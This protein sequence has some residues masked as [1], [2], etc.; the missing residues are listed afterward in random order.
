MEHDISKGYT[1][2]NGFA[3]TAISYP[4]NVHDAI[5]V[6]CKGVSDCE[7]PQ[8]DIPDHT[9]EDYVIFIN[10]MKIQKAVI[11]L[12]N[13]ACI[14]MCPSLKYIQ[15]IPSYQ[16]DAS[17]VFSPLYEMPEIKSLSCQNRYGSREQFISEVDYSRIRG[18]I[19]LSI[20]VNRKTLN[21]NRVKTLK[22]LDVGGFKGKNHDLTDLFSSEELDTLR[23][24]QCGMYSLNGIETSRKMQ[25]LY[26]HYN[27]SLRD[28]SALGKVKGTLKA[29]RIENCP[30]IED[31]SVLGELEN[32]ELLELSGNNVLP[33]LNFL[34]TMKNLKTL[35]FNMN[36]L[37]GDLSPCLDLCYVYSE[38][39]RK[40]YNLQD[41]DLPKKKYIRG[42]EGIDE[43][44][45]L[46]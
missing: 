31:F 34:K 24:I 11:I 46:E 38:K 21:Y 29:L 10:K 37:C 6:K 26:L 17:F 7:V 35:I 20:N 41:E 28:I 8:Y 45:R 36:V 43:W 3:F 22:S 1:I 39:N 40:H 18:L 14:N 4:F 42:N 16:A 25:C 23:L 2:T 12:N 44:R 32:L 9:I 5:I 15:I 27:R 19:S 30:K 13:I 33:N